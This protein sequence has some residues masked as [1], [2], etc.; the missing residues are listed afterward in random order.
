MEVRKSAIFIKLS[1]K[2][3]RYSEMNGDKNFENGKAED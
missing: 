1:W 2:A 3:A